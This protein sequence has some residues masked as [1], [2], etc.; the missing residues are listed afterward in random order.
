MSINRKMDFKIWYVHIMECYSATKKL[1]H[2]KT[3]MYLRHEE[4]GCNKIHKVLFHLCG[5][6]EQI[7]LVYNEKIRIVLCLGRGRSEP[8]GMIELF[9]ILTDVG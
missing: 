4:L 2:V 5:F 8:F 7:K 3:W 1:I 9:H 6:L